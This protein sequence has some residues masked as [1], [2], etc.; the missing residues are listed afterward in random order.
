[1]SQVFVGKLDNKYEFVFFLEG[2]V[3]HD[4][5]R[6]YGKYAYTKYGV[7]IWLRGEIKGDEYHLSED[8]GYIKFKREG[9][10]LIGT[11]QNKAKTKT[12][13][14]EATRL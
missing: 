14:F 10:K 8:N 12:R 6:I 1:M 11:W 3:P 7:G 9:D 13:L 2:S 5:R 4:G